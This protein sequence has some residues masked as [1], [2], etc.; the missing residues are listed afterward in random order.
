M[1]PLSQDDIA[2]EV[3]KDY[4]V[5]DYSKK[6]V[7]EGVELNKLQSFSDDGGYF[8]ELSRFVNERLKEFQDFS[9]EQM[10]FSQ[11]LP[12]V[13]KAAHLH[14]K[15][16]DIWF[17]PLS[18]R[19]L[20]GL[21][22]C[23][24]D[25]PTKGEKMRFVMGGGRAELLYIPRGV[26]HGAANLWDKPAHVIY[27]VNN[28]FDPDPEKTDEGRLPWDTFGEGFWELSKE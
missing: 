1:K 21:M 9:I 8:V 27:F 15:Q 13:V 10:N 7:I 14:L 18:D 12:G 22:D 5:Q 20:V 4:N 11:M 24:E 28:P 19:L 25:S 26:A 6:P 17:V 2:K 3:R 16:E 23:R